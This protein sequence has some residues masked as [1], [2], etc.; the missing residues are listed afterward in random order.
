MP[1]GSSAGSRPYCPSFDGFRVTRSQS[2]DAPP[3]L[4]VLLAGAGAWSLRS[5]WVDAAYTEA[6]AD[7]GSGR[8]DAR[9]HALNQ[10]HGK[11]V[12]P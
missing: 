2:L 7:Y 5:A 6:A 3:I 12:G 8:G 9:L 10:M 1:C 11:A 4:L